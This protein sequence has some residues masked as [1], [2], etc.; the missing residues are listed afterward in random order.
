MS[1]RTQLTSFETRVLQLA[2]DCTPFV[3]LF[4]DLDSCTVHGGSV[5]LD[6]EAGEVEVAALPEHSDSEI[7]ALIEDELDSSAKGYAAAASE[8]RYE[9][10]QLG[11]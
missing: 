11:C 6:G 10:S 2:I 3:Q 9:R 1:Q 5:F 7:V 8:D 4:T